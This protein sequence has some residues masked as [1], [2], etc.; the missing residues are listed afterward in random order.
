MSNA[1]QRIPF[2]SGLR[3]VERDEGEVFDVA[4]AR[5]T[6]KVKGEET[7]YAFS[8]CEQRLEPG[9]GVLLHCHAYSEVFYVLS[10]VV[11]FLRVTDDGQEWVTCS[12]GETAIIPIN[13]PHAFYNLTE[14]PARLLGISTHLHQVFFD[15]VV[16]A[17]RAE[18]FAE[19]PLHDA[20][21]RIGALAQK[22]SMHF[23][24]FEPPSRT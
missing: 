12:A 7:G 3:K 2:R 11:E 16:E 17:D 21:E 9:E 19:M 5:I 24:P 14:Q 6:W 18:S 1:V 4:G 23:F 13:A 20:M 15:A 10:G 22:F 8:I